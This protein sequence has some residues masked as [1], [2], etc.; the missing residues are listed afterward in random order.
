MAARRVWTAVIALAVLAGAAAAGAAL[1]WR[2]LNTAL[3]STADG[4]WL[5]IESGTSFYRVTADLKE[6][7][8]LDAPWLLAG[9]ARFNGDA[10][11]I[12]A[13]E[14]QIGAGTTPLTLARSINASMESSG[15]CAMAFRNRRPASISR[16][17]RLRHRRS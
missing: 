14:Y 8:L 6:R 2:E 5:R 17:R 11:R 7:G 13:G 15:R 4:A 10:T 16:P 12:R 9:Y 1:A 3:P